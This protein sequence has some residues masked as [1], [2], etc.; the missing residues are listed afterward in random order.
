MDYVTG[1]GTIPVRAQFDGSNRALAHRQIPR[2]L[3]A[4]GNRHHRG[5]TGAGR[6]Q[7]SGRADRNHRR[8]RRSKGWSHVI[9]DIPALRD[10]D[11]LD[12]VGIA[13][14]DLGRQPLEHD[15]LDGRPLDLRCHVLSQ[16]PLTDL[17]EYDDGS[18]ATASCR[19]QPVP[20]RYVSVPSREETES[21]G[22]DFI[23]IRV[24]NDD[25]ET[26]CLSNHEDER[27]GRDLH[28]RYD[29]QLCVARP[30]HGPFR[31][32]GQ[33]TRDRSPHLPAGNG[34]GEHHQLGRADVERELD[35][36]VRDAETL[37]RSV[38]HALVGNVEEAHQ[39]VV[40]LLHGQREGQLLAAYHD[41]AL[42]I[43]LYR[44]RLQRRCQGCKR[45]KAKPKARGHRS[46]PSR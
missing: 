1:P 38:G 11:G 32:F 46:V 23:A 45:E 43:A 13:L 29:G 37:E 34:S 39:T 15:L 31:A 8:I 2:L 10:D 6:T 21:V 33:R 9:A 19:D 4:L 7:G 42:P 41:R 24:P 17:C 40:T 25:R 14:L 12:P 36:A 18:G 22:L 30:G 27:G 26:G 3:H 44:L 35:G 16:R 5:F 20:D 28:G